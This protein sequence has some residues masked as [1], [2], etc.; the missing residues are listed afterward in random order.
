MQDVML[1]LET[2]G[3]NSNSAIVSIGAVEF[4]ARERVL[5]RHFYMVVDLASAVTAGGVM[6]ASTVLWWLQQSESARKELAPGNAST[7]GLVLPAFYDWFKAVGGKYLWG[8][9]ADFDCV[10]LRNAY[11][12][13]NLEPPWDF[14]DSRCFRT[15]KAEHPVID[16]S[17]WQSDHHNALSDAEW[18]AKYL[19]ELHRQEF[20]K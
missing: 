1:D 4:D 10:I 15:V 7:I 11:K 3:N 5:G 17:K 6:D 12:N 2:M 13:S 9:G 18:Q 20:R 16:T 8:N 14:R 19:I